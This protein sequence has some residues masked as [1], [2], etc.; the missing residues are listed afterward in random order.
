MR[1]WLE[2]DASRE[3]ESDLPDSL[4]KDME[5]AGEAGLKDTDV[6]G[7]L[8]VGA[9]CTPPLVFFLQRQ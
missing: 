2:A 3:S 1:A 9:I 5:P 8:G 4:E 7:S 6:F